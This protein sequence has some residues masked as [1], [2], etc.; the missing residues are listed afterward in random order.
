MTCVTI[1]NWRLTT[2]TYRIQFS[3]HYRYEKYSN[4]KQKQHMTW[5]TGKMHCLHT[6]NWKT[7]T[8]QFKCVDKLKKKMNIPN[9]WMWERKKNKYQSDEFVSKHCLL[10][11]QKRI[12]WWK[13]INSWVSSNLSPV[14]NVLTHANH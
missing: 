9:K 5:T 10:N 12:T 14:K 6:D 11:E 1:T 7:N 4:E 3:F 13:R 8:Q 2:H